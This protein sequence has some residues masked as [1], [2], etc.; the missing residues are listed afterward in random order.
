MKTIDN[1]PEL[2]GM[3]KLLISQYSEYQKSIDEDVKLTFITDYNELTKDFTVVFS[4]VRE[5]ILVH[6]DPESSHQEYDEVLGEE[7]FI[8]HETD[9]LLK[10]EQYVSDCLKPV[11]ETKLYSAAL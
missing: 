4:W 6:T 5:L 1:T 10:L 2:V 7:K 11:S 9:S 3:V 8:I